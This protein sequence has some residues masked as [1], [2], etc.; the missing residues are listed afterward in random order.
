MVTEPGLGPGW[1]PRPVL[2]GLPEVT[3]HEGPGQLSQ[4]SGD[5]AR[6]YVLWPRAHVK[7]GF[8]HSGETRT[9]GF[10]TSLRHCVPLGHLNVCPVGLALTLSLPAWLAT[11]WT[12]E[13]PWETP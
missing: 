11:C 1:P 8:A 13:R 12:L 4:G 3:S 7:C 5:S 6:W 9:W 10:S 2:H